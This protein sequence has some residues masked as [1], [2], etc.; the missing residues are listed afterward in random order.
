MAT[1]RTDPKTGEIIGVTLAPGEKPPPEWLEARAAKNRKP[2]FRAKFEFANKNF[3]AFLAEGI[4]ED[5]KLRTRA[6]IMY[7]AYLRWFSGKSELIEKTPMTQRAF[8]MRMKR[9]YLWGR[10]QGRTVTYRGVAPI[11]MLA[12]SVESANPQE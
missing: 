6:G 11:G 10:G 4:Q 1:V 2:H 7:S 5:E 3:T 9:A 12:V 8:G